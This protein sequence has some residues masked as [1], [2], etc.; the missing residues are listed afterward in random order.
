MKNLP[1]INPMK[2]LYSRLSKVGFTRA[3][4]RKTAL[5]SWWDDEAANSPSGY[6][7]VLLL[8]SRHLGV[9]LASL[10]DSSAAIRLRAFGLCKFKKAGNV[11]E[12]DLALSRV[13]ATRAAQLAAEATPKPFE[14]LPANAGEIRQQILDGNTRWVGLRDLTRWCW[15]RGIPV[16]HFDHFPKNARRPHGFAALVQDR[17]VIVLC[18]RAKYSAWLLFILAHEL[19]HIA[20]GHISSDGTLIDDHIDEASTDLEEQQANAFALELLTGSA[21]KRIIAVGRWPNASDLAEAAGQLGRSGMID[22]GHIVLNYAHSMGPTFYAVGNAALK[23]LESKN[24][25]VGI[26]RTE[27]AERLDWSRLPEDSSEF[28]MRVTRETAAE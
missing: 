12:D 14:S 7:H 1:L 28:L 22:P 5:P 18:K 20:L 26:V 4:I 21:T 23:Q 25:A 15:D 13:M 8:L 6:A 2:A 3:Y 9:E 17:P 10:Q 24:H 16:L 19:G 27:M 11:S